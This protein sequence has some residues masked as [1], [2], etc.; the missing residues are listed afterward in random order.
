[1]KDTP[2]LYAG[3][4]AGGAPVMWERAVREA[5]PSI[6]ELAPPESQVLELG[7]GDGLLTCYMCREL[8]WRVVGLE[9]DQEGQ[10]LAQEHA[11]QF[12]LSDRLEFRCLEPGEVFNQRGQYDAVFIKTVLYLSE[13][14]EEYGRW[15]DWILTVLRPGGV[16]INFETGRS[17]SLTQLYRTLRR[18]S[19]TR[20]C[21]YDRRVEGL[22][23]ERFAILERRY[24]GG[25]SQFA[26]PLPPLYRLAACVEERWRPRQADNCFIV[27]IIARRPG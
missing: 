1:M 14:L 6:R 4:T 7:Y 18:R 26:A 21:L 12:G 13:T 15:L 23:D 25:L 19:Y 8:G 17:N 9:V 2:E 24:Y 10:R 20:L 22:Y 16:F 3:L 5:L 27:S 11:Q